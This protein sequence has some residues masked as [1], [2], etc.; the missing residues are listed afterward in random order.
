M[1]YRFETRDITRFYENT[2]G[3]SVSKVDDKLM[4]MQ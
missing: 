3:Q 2:T 1:R 4:K